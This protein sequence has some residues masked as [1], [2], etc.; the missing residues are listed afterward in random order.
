MQDAAEPPARRP[1]LPTAASG[2]RSAWPLRRRC[3]SGLD[4]RRHDGVDRSFQRLPTWQLANR[5]IDIQVIKDYAA[6]LTEPL[7]ESPK[8]A[9]CQ[10]RSKVQDFSQDALGIGTCFQLGERREIQVDGRTGTTCYLANGLFI[11]KQ[12][13]LGHAD[14][15]HR[16][17][18][19]AG[20]R[21]SHG[22]RNLVV[23]PLRVLPLCVTVHKYE[24]QGVAQFEHGSESIHHSTSRRTWQTAQVGCRGSNIGPALQAKSLQVPAQRF[25]GGSICDEY[26]SQDHWG[27]M[28]E[29]CDPAGL[30]RYGRMS[31][32]VTECPS[33]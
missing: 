4:E 5:A 22:L 25:V 33:G 21:F 31:S 28:R 19:W 32:L 30:V 3:D 6:V 14:G 27:A 1:G 2:R 13:C 17:G 16:H 10:T 26:G 7:P 11:E 24:V 8:T 23:S 18:G 29:I 20:T 15:N 12:P 9:T